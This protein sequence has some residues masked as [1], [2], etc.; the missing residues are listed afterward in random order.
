VE[1][2]ERSFVVDDPLVGRS[3]GLAAAS[4]SGWLLGRMAGF[5]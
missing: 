1:P 3:G 2:P 5:P 4:V